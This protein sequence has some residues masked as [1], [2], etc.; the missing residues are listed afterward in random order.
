MF[1]RI[2]E[3][4]PAVLTYHKGSQ[5]SYVF[6]IHEKDYVRYRKIIDGVVSRWRMIF[7]EEYTKMGNVCII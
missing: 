3:A 4:K 5:R 6:M 1:E 2:P 7:S